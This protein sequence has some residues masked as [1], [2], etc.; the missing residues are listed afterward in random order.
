MPIY[1]PHVFE[2]IINYTIIILFINPSTV[3]IT[4]T[5]KCIHK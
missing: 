1:S 2:V 5:E 3:I 4:A